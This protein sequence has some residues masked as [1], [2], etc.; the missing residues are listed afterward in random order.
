MTKAV[1]DLA[2][3]D[4]AVTRPGGK[5]WALKLTDDQRERIAAAKEAG[6]AGS[7]IHRVVTG[8]WGIVAG[9]Q[10]VLR[11]LRGECACATA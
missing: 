9:K 10:Q 11:H 8:N 5:C 6:H 4:A 2:E 7:T 3:F 1:L